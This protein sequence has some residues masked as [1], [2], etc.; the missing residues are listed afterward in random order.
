MTPQASL[1]SS[2]ENG[3]HR[4]SFRHKLSSS[5]SPISAVATINDAV[6]ETHDSEPETATALHARGVEHAERGE[7]SIAA[8]LFG[9]AAAVRPS[10]PALH[11]DLGEAFRNLGDGMRA[12]GC[13]RIALNLRPDDPDA[14]NM[15]GLA[16][17][18]TGRR[19]E[20]VESFRQAL[21][22]RPDSVAVHNNL[23]VVLR[24]LGRTKEAIAHFRQAVTLDPLVFRVH[25]NLGMALLHQGQAEEALE[26]LREAVRLQPEMAILHHNLAIVLRRLG[27]DAEAM[28]A[29][30]EGGR[31]DPDLTIPPPHTV[32]IPQEPVQPPGDP[33][34]AVLNHYLGDSLQTQGRYVDARAA[35][36]EALRLDS[37]RA[38][39]HLQIGISLKQ[40]G[41]LDEALPWLEMAVVL[42]SEDPACWEH[43]AQLQGERDEPGEA[44]PCWERVLAL[45]TIKKAATHIALGWALQEEGRLPEARQH[46]QAA[47]RL[48]PDSGAAQLHLGGVHAESGDLAEAE[49]AFR[50]ALRL[51]PSMIQPHAR[52]AA[53]LRG[54]LPDADLDALARRLGD[55]RLGAAARARLLFGLAHVLDARHDY[56]R[57]ADCMLEANALTLETARAY[58]PA[59]HTL[60][61][62]GLLQAF[63]AGF[64]ARTAAMG[65]ETRR[66]VFIFGLPRSGTT[67]IEQVLAS[68]PR[69]HGCGELRLGRRSFA[70][71]PSVLGRP[72]RPMECI[73]HLDAQSIQCLAE[74]HLEQLAHQDGGQS[75]RIVDKM[76]DNYLYL[77]LLAAMLPRATFIHCRR[78]LH[79]V[80]VS[81]WMTDFRTIRWANDPSHI[82]SRFHEYRRLM[83]HWRAV[84]PVR[85]HEV[86]YEETVSDPRKRRRAPAAGRLWPG[87]G[88][89]LPCVSPHRADGPH[90]QPHPGPPA[91][92]H[93]FRRP[94]E[95]LRTGAG[96]SV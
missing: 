69:V 73:P 37:G 33:S 96:R 39:T 76:P 16:L 47:A 46:Y 92:L 88:P 86:D 9:R 27:R 10:V 3:Y 28:A 77:G 90:R 20:A 30:L 93:H 24:E 35:Y 40:E 26:P 64:F 1:A 71:I 84:L 13:C 68:H 22:V 61:V 18:Q 89:R 75:A 43:L 36:L 78:D 82:A 6:A 7:Y 65:L 23:G 31:L 58:D 11:I 29:E 94:L 32:P 87:V 70:A 52:L 54:K 81:C 53:L 41:Q 56:A 17:Q 42:T 57:A 55:P 67:L 95:A 85:L 83:D 59:E 66:P 14:L 91:D 12:A 79:D 19:E 80:A 72:E 48:E 44:I 50:A 8:D 62:D 21:E 4:M 63:D 5:V 34:L 51:Q 15:L 38:A 49:A 45:G 60:H 2:S 74:Q 25:T